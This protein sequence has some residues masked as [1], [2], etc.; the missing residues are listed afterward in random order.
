MGHTKPTY[1]E[2][3]QEKDNLLKQC[4][5]YKTIVDYSVEWEILML[6]S[7]EFSYVSPSCHNITGYE[8]NEFIE[9]PDLFI[10]IIH[11]LDKGLVDEHFY[12]KK[13]QIEKDT[14][15]EFRIIT[16]DGKQKWIE[17]ICQKAY[18]TK[19]QFV[20]YRSSN[21]DITKRKE[22]ELTIKQTNKVLTE[23]RHLF[24]QGNVVVFKWKNS[25]NWPVEYVSQNI[26]SVFGYTPE[27]IQSP[28]FKYP[29]II[30]P[31][32]LERVTSEVTKFT[33]NNLNHFEHK[34]YRIIDKNGQIRWVLD[35]TIILRNDNNEITHYTG[36]LV[37]ITQQKQIENQLRKFSQVVEQSPAIVVITDLD[38][39]IEY[40]NSK[41]TQ[42]TGYTYEEVIG[43]NP[44]ILKS[45]EHSVEFYKELWETI[46]SG[47]E[48]RGDLRNKKKNGA[49]NYERALISPI[50]DEQ[51]KIIKYTK[52]AEDV[53]ELKKAE[54]Q[55]KFHSKFQDVL[56]NIS[57]RYINIPVQNVEKDI[58]SALCEIG[59]FVEADRSYI[60]DYDFRRQVCINTYEWCREGIEPQIDNLQAVPLSEIPYWVDAHVKGE[61]MYIPDVYALPDNGL[62]AILE[63]Q[64]IKSLITVPMMY[65]GKCIGFIGFDSVRFYHTYTNREKVLLEVFS[66]ILVNIQM[67]VSKENDL[68]MAKEK[69]EESNRLKSAFLANMSHEIRTPM[70]GILGFTELLLDP[71]LDSEEKEDYIKIIHKSGQRMLNTVNDIVEISKI[72]AGLVNV[73]ERETDINQTVEEL[74]LFFSPEAE[75]KGLKLTFEKAL[76]P[77]KKNILTDPNKLNSILTNLIKNAI[78]YTDSGE[79]NVGCQLKGPE[80]KFY[81]KDTGIGIPAHRQKAIFNRFE[82]ADIFDKRAFEGLGLG[83]AISKSYV[84]MLN[85]KIWVESKEGIGSTFYFILPAKSN[86]STKPVEYQKKKSIAKKLKILLA[87]DDEI[88]RNYISIILNDYTAELLQAKTGTEAVELCRKNYDIDLILMDIKMPEMNGYETTQKIRAFN[89]KVIIIAQTAYGLSGDKEKAIKAGCNDYIS[90]PIIK[91]KLQELIRKYFEKV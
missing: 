73:M 4:A 91:T 40:V 70:N 49:L 63:P 2:L 48:W 90:K 53:T 77:G 14:V 88:S 25:E 18:D 31:E 37:D 8:A 84:E 21:R 7:G 46:S 13:Q 29:K 32:D 74:I 59:E 58:N 44:R 38:E 16:K 22:A 24:T 41:F 67:R 6:P 1:A 19:G 23:E 12:R 62:R 10:E 39:N 87:E 43:Q 51:G 56:M 33:K 36:Y 83:L 3:Q 64:Q 55:L 11:P 50:F 68:I 47:K 17:H 45:G 9:N 82:Q 80:L 85:G 71:H 42:I 60:F 15:L 26:K 52:V 79:I 61:P 65:Q 89:N 57:T 28:Q 20:G 72:E 86:L 5:H 27:E 54:E 78:K 30:F 81:I 69:A 66:Q 76:P 35:Y 75:E 34:P